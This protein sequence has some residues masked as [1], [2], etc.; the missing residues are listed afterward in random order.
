MAEQQVASVCLIGCGGIGA[1]HARAAMAAPEAVRYTAVFDTDPVRAEALLQQT[2]LAARV[3]PTWEAVLRDPELDGVDLCL[4]NSL[5]AQFAIEAM[6]AG[7]HV[8]TEKPM[9]LSIADCDR[10]IAVSEQT[11][12]L[13]TVIHNRRFDEPALALKALIDSGDLGD[14]FLVETHGIEGPNT[15]GRGR[16]LASEAEGGIAMAQTVHF[17]YMVRWLLG[18]VTEVS[19]FTSRKGIDW[20]DGAVSC[21]IMLRFASDAIGEMTSTFGQAAGK[22]EHRITVYGGEGIATHTHN[23]LRVICP[24]R[25]GDEEWHDIA[26]PDQS[27]GRGFN[28]QV[29]AF[30][31]AISPG[32]SVAVPASEGREAVALIEAAYRSAATRQ[33]VRLPLTP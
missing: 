12:R 24:A 15:V 6:E 28:V 9:A 5:H 26:F 7:K 1:R 27:W 4:P 18:P 8:L 2:G 31:R 33:A 22:N 17:A 10:M 13:L 3:I 32:G 16:W 11:G 23:S 21:V 19:C 30:G 20:M 14:P 29:A 25:F